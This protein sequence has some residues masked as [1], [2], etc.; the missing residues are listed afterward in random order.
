MK[1]TLRNIQEKD[2]ESSYPA[3]DT[4]NIPPF[5][6][7]EKDNLLTYIPDSVAEDLMNNLIKF[8]DEHP[9]TEIIF[10][11]KKNEETTQIHQKS[12]SQKKT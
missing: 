1:F 3:P 12:P 8:M 10:E 11:E 5:I 4:P 7:K 9:E 2:M 6:I